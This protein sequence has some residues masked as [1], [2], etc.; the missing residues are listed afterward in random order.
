MKS[1]RPK[2]HRVCSMTA[3]PILAVWAALFFWL[4]AGFDSALGQVPSGKSFER[5]VEDN[6]IGALTLQFPVRRFE[7]KDRSGPVVFTHGMIHIADRPFYEQH[8]SLLDPLDVVLFEAV[9]PAG[10]G[11]PEHSLQDTNSTEWKINTTRMRLQSLAIFA[12]GYAVERGK[13]PTNFQDLLK[14]DSDIRPFADRLGKDAWGNDFQFSVTEREPADR[15]DR[16]LSDDPDSEGTPSVATA[17]PNQALDII[18]WGADEAKGGVGEGADIR[19][20]DQPPIYMGT[21]DENSMPRIADYLGLIFQG[22]VEKHGKANWRSSDLSED[23]VSERFAAQGMPEE[24]KKNADPWMPA[25][26]LETIAE[27][28]HNI[29]GLKNAG[30]VF[31]IDTLAS[32]PIRMQESRGDAFAKVIIEDRNQVVIDDLQ[33]ILDNEPEIKSIGIIYGAAHMP[34]IESRLL[35]MGFEETRTDWLNAINVELPKDPA[36]RK[37]LQI[38]RSTVRSMGL[39]GGSDAAGGVK[40]KR[41]RKSNTSEETLAQDYRKEVLRAHVGELAKLLDADREAD[42]EKAEKDL[43]ALSSLAIPFLPASSADD[44]DEFRNRIERI[45]DTLLERDKAML[46]KPSRVNIRGKMTGKQALESLSQQ[47]GNALQV[48]NVSGLDAEID[49]DLEDMLFWEA[50]DEILDSLALS[51]P[52]SDGDELRL[53]PR[54]EFM[55]QRFVMASYAGSFRLEPIA[56][57]KEQRQYEPELNAT[58][59]ELLLAWEPRLNPVFVRY[60]LEGLELKC[61]NGEI[62]RPKKDQGTDFT[63]SGSQLI[64]ILNFDRPSRSAKEIVEWRGRLMCVVPGKPVALSF[65]DLDTIRNETSSNGDLEVTLERSRKNR[66]VYEILVGVSLRGQQASDSMQGWTSMVDAYLED[67]QGNRVQHAGWSTT[68]ITDQDVG[69]AFLFEVDESLAGYRFVFIAPQSIMQQT[70]EYSL[71]G[72][73]LP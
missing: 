13:L 14:W 55:P 1:H 9:L 35:E 48:K 73:A 60:E 29:P 56:V 59:I 10:I 15:R 65:K 58:S 69:L 34:D 7:R 17:R 18:S 42:R 43:M 49:I 41:W 46:S 64:S 24:T 31:F 23:Q 68:R 50:L 6:E 32:S 33:A 27:L 37:Q 3:G 11:R 67:E 12:R 38:S 4:C 44:S 45:R 70:V 47:T 5:I 57:T 16:E 22:K 61:D 8:Q 52:P 28:S 72:I 40:R 20:S 53:V 36:E 71:G 51:I 63:P 25:R 21:P 19:L 39:L 54:T 30:K 26:V 2:A 62:L 66:D